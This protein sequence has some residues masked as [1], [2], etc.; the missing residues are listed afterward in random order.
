MKIRHTGI[1]VSDIDKAL[2]FYNELLG[3]KIVKDAQETG[4]F[5]D[6]ILGF[7]GVDVRTIKLGAGGS[8]I[9]LLYFKSYPMG[10]QTRGM[11]SLGCTHIALTVNNLDN[12]FKMLKVFQ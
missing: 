11:T 7:S 9:E 3:F 5:I 2:H 6:K 12:C 1:V 4:P 10:P 8:L